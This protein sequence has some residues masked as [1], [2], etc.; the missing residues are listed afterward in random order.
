MLPTCR[1]S[2]RIPTIATTHSGR[3]RPPVPIDRDQCGAGAGHQPIDEHYAG[4]HPDVGKS[5]LSVLFDRLSPGGIIV[6][7][8]YGW[9]VHFKQ[10]EAIDTFMN[11]KGIPVLELPTGQAMSIKR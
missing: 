1:S 5:H 9:A 10:K 4:D 7:D 8:D 3:S 2:V 11:A 6:F